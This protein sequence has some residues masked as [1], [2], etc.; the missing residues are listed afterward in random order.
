MRAL[1]KL[2]CGVALA[3]APLASPAFAATSVYVDAQANIFAAGLGSIP[4]AGGGAGILPPSLAVSG[5]Q[6]LTITA[7]GQADP[8]GGYGAHGPD[9][10]SLTSNISNATGS[11]IGNFNDP[12]SLALLGV[13]T[14]SG[15]GVD[16][17]FKIGSGG[18]FSVPTGATMFYLGFADAYGFQGTS[19]YYADNTGGFTA[20]VSGA[21]G[22]PEP[23]TWAMMIVGF[24]MVG[25]GLR[26]RF[27]RAATA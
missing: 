12:M 20:L 10:F 13:F 19:G 5:G 22:V 16:T 2:M 26:I 18:T 11:S 15:A 9:G 17:I 21:G 1:S 24:G 8:G 6:T 23:A 4:S 14:G 27:R 7:T 25:A 3:A